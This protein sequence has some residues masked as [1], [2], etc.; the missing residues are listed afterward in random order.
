MPDCGCFHPDR[1][2]GEDADLAE[3]IVMQAYVQLPLLPR[4][5]DGCWVATLK[6]MGD[7]ELRLIE[8]I[9]ACVG[10]P[11]LRVE[12][13]DRLAHKVVEGHDCDEIEN[14]VVA[15]REMVSRTT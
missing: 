5:A 14:A 2:V 12:L 9:S 13:F 1:L 8:R 10:Q 11:V 7:Q 3:S 15:F 4:R 6:R